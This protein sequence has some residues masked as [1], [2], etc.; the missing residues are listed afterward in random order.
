MGYVKKADYIAK[1]GE[2]AWDAYTAKRNEYGKQWRKEHREEK[3]E[4][5]RRWREE[6]PDYGKQWYQENKEQRTE[7]MKQYGKTQLGRAKYLKHGYDQKDSDRGFSTDQN[8][9]ED[10]IIKH[11][12]GSSCIYCGESDWT[13]LGCDR[14]DNTK[15]HTPDNVVC[16]CW[17]CNKERKNK[18]TVEEFIQYRKLHPREEQVPVTEKM[19]NFRSDYF[20]IDRRILGFLGMKN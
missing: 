5:D 11:V 2:E 4:C 14:I 18:F 15:G 10:W 17:D 19:G 16:S 12:F 9:D 20:L 1:Y 13:K 3:K 8:I 6:H 7:Q